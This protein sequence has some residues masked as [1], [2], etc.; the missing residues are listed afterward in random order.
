MHGFAN[1]E[2]D[3]QHSANALATYRKAMPMYERAG[4]LVGVEAMH[5][6]I[7]QQLQRIRDLDGAEREMLLALEMTRQ[8]GERHAEGIV[9]E[10]LG[11][12]YLDRGEPERALATMKQAT[13]IARAIKDATTVAQTR[14]KQGESLH[15]LGRTREAEEAFKDGV[16]QLD[17]MGETAR[18][19]EAEAL[20]RA[21]VEQHTRAGVD[22]GEADAA[23]ATVLVAAGKVAEAAAA[24]DRAFA[25]EPDEL[26]TQLALA[27]VELAEK[28]PELAIA[29]LQK[30]LAAPRPEVPL[31]LEAE[32]LE[33]RALAA[34]GKSAAS[35]AK[36][37]AIAAEAK[38]KGFAF[39]E[40]AASHKP[41]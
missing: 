21:A 13:E 15:A 1:I 40:K 38:Q 26:H 31:R 39:V 11:G 41:R 16:G 6:N 25:H 32:L 24:A 27:H 30:A 37:R 29:R 9:T 33:A 12:L 34:T 36:L 3:M 23:L 8:L 19:G 14:R 2:S 22:S 4:N 20:A 28:H 7:G 18:I 17:A 5:I 35:D 10:S